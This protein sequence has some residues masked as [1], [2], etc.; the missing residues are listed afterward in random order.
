[1]IFILALCLVAGSFTLSAI[2]TALVRRI[3]LKRDFVARPAADRFHQSVIPLGGGIA[4][5]WTIIIF[6][7]AAAATVKFL[8]AP[9]HLNFLGE[10]ITIHTEGFLGKFSGLMVIVGCTLA[11][12]LVG[13]WDDKK[14]LGAFI[15]L[16]FQFAIATV[17]AVFADIRVEL[18]IENTFITTALSVIWIVMIMNSFNFLH[19]M[20]GLSVGIAAIAASVLFFAA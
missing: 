1:M 6:L 2:L 19:N 15:K 3:S 8:L 13:L 16:F 11:L 17:A 14:H 9:G 10:N 4:I 12:H 20:D 7:L 5:S 18:F